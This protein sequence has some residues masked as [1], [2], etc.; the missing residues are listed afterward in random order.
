MESQDRCDLIQFQQDRFICNWRKLNDFH[1]YP[2]YKSLKEKFVLSLSTLQDFLNDQDLGVVKPNQCE[3]SYINSIV[4]P[5]DSDPRP[6]MAR[7]F[8]FWAND[9][10]DTAGRDIEDGVIKF[11]YHL[12]G[13]SNE[14][15]A[16]LYVSIQPGLVRETGKPVIQMNLTVKGRPDSPSLPDTLKFMDLGRNAIVRAFTSLT[17]PEM[18]SYWGIKNV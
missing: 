15:Y 1:V 10:K 11:R 9:Y 8:K 16:R 18:H 13:E 3:V 4:L 17:R 14:P 12:F 7:I 6:Q 5:D 2:R